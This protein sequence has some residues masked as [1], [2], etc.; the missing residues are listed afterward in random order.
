MRWQKDKKKS[1]TAILTFF[2]A[3]LVFFIHF[4]C[5]YCITEDTS[6]RDCTYVRFEHQDK[7]DGGKVEDRAL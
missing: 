1:D 3:Q 6:T 5:F 4:C 7:A 2:L